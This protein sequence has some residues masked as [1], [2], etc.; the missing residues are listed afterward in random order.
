MFGKIQRKELIIM[1]KLVIRIVFSVIL[2]FVP[3][4]ASFALKGNPES[5]FNGLDVAYY[6]A[7]VFCTVL[8]VFMLY[9]GVLD[10]FNHK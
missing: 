1:K 5:W 2:L 4:I 3:T 10:Y 6:Q 9:K 7:C 8:A